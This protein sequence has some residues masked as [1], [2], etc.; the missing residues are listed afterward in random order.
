MSAIA[1]CVQRPLFVTIALLIPCLALA[2]AAPAQRP[3]GTS[4]AAVFGS[5]CFQCHSAGMWS[6]HRAD[7]RGWESVLYRMVGRG[8]LWSEEEIGRMANY[9]AA[10]FGPAGSKPSGSAKAQREKP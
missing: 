3:A 8:A 1:R 5:L 10:S 9:L 7:K 6:D 4:D 2:Q